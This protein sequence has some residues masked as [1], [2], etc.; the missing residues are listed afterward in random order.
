[1]CELSTLTP[2]IRNPELPP[3]SST[4]A[5]LYFNYFKNGNLVF[6]I[7]ENGFIKFIS[8]I[9]KNDTE[10]IN[11]KKIK[12][13][14]I[15]GF[16][17]ITFSEQE[18]MRPYLLIRNLVLVMTLIFLYISIILVYLGGNIIV[19]PILYLRM[20]V[21]KI[22]N[23]L[24]D[25]I[26][27]KVRVNANI[28]VF[29]DI[30]KS[31]DEIKLLSKEINNMVTIIRGIIPYISAS[32]LKQA[33]KDE[34]LSEEK[35]LAFL[36]TDIRGFT[37]MCEGMS[38]NE[39]VD[40]LNKYLNLETEI[41]LNNHGDVDKFVGDELMAFFEGPQKEINACRAAMQLRHAMMN[42]KDIRQKKGLPIVNIGIGINTGK[43]VFGSVGAKDRMDF[44]SIGDTVNLAARLEGANKEFGTKALISEFVYSSIK[45]EFLCREID[46]ITVKGK[47]LPVRIYEILQEKSLV[48]PKLLEIKDLFEKGLA[49]Y[50]NRNWEEALK[51][52]NL[53][54]EQFNDKPSEIFIIRVKHFILNPPNPTWDGVFNMTIK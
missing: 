4:E 7:N 36:F 10:I 19:N 15:L 44:T 2:N 41:I 24:Q 39:V 31:H 6:N 40:V 18:I 26:S 12:R 37:T 5:L 48:Q 43:V 32:T 53:N 35:D 25:M 22:S 28:L 1:M 17:I 30:I 42:E 3:I 38:P 21:N 46:Y 34:L 33:D 23:I 45:E 51:C 54:Y 27:G 9:T 8:P 29:E 13:D 16:S 49:Q 20:N 52:F 50:R 47:K 11:N 14:R